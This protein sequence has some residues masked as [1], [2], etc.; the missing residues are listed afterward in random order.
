MSKILA[1]KNTDPG[2]YLTDGLKISGRAYVQIESE[3]PPY[4]IHAF[5]EALDKGYI[6]LVASIYEHEQTFNLLKENV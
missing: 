1:L 2:F 5:K 4:I 3:C 6:K